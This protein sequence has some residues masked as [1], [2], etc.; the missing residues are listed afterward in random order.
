MAPLFAGLRGLPAVTVGFFVAHLASTTQAST[1]S[2]MPALRFN[3][4]IRPILSENCFQCHGPDKNHRKG[5]LRLDVREE[6]L[7]ALAWV[8]GDAARSDA[9]KR[10]F[11]DDPDEQ[12]PPKD[13]H[14]TL[15][16]R[17]KE[18]LRRWVAEGAAYEPHWAS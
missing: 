15:S 7:E 1:T 17:Q 12:M 10:I 3:R 18:T 6:A 2:S 4:D 5:D 8:P 13:S 11:S 9:V 14:R 16:T